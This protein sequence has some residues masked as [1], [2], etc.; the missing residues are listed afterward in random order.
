[1]LCV[2]CIAVDTQGKTNDN[3]TNYEQRSSKESSVNFVDLLFKN[4]H[5]KCYIVSFK[6]SELTRS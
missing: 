1:M 5:L 2:A 4:D 3:K 6:R